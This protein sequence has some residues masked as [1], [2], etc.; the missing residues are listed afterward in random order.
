M[1]NVL[2]GVLLA[3]PWLACL[4]LAGAGAGS[5]PRGR[6][7]VLFT[8][9]LI[10]VG[11][12]FLLI[13]HEEPTLAFG[14][15]LTHVTPAATLSEVAWSA[16][17]FSLVM[18]AATMLLLA[19]ATVLLPDD[20]PAVW[21]VTLLVLGGVL[22]IW[23]LQHVWWI[24]GATI[25]V[26]FLALLLPTAGD[27]PHTA[28]PARSLW[29]T[30]TVGDLALIVA[31]IAG[32]GGIG[33]GTV[34]RFDDAETV[35]E[36]AAM[37][38]A[39]AMFVGFWW[40]IGILGRAGQFPLCVMFDRVRTYRPLAWVTVVGVSVFAIGWRWCDLGHAWWAATPSVF[41]LIISGALASALLCAWFAACTT[42]FRVRVAYLTAAQISLGLG[43][44]CTGEADERVWASAVV[45]GTIGL[46]VWCWC[47][48]TSPADSTERPD[49]TAAAPAWARVMTGGEVSTVAW[50]WSLSSPSVTSSVLPT[51]APSART[52]APV[53][54]LLWCGL[55]IAAGS[56][57]W[58][59]EPLQMIAD[60]TSSA[61]EAGSA[62]ENIA[63]QRPNGS[64][65]ISALAVGLISSSVCAG[66]RSLLR[67]SG[68]SVHSLPVWVASLTLASLPA[69]VL[70]LLSH[71]TGL[72]TT[73]SSHT[74]PALACLA[75]AA[76]VTGWVWAG[77][78]IEQ[79]RKAAEP[80]NLIRQLGAQRLLIP[81]LLQFGANFP[82]RG[83]AQMFRFLDWSVLE[84]ACWGR[85]RNFPE[86][87]RGFTQE[88]R[89][90][91]NGSYTLVLWVSGTA[92]VTTVV[93]LA[94]IAR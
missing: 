2:L 71:P 86:T 63:P 79:Q 13:R 84:I 29:L 54:A 20:A 73:L 70:V 7:T 88:L 23:W 90:A 57:W 19:A 46:A 28:G 94:H 21:M 16:N 72:W 93:W 59:D 78:P 42:D 35:R 10:G 17:R 65:P 12:L 34:G 50:Q 6:Q 68:A 60:S 22:Q 47:V 55:A 85:L 38:P 25:L 26:S 52:M 77:W 62:L 4:T 89:D 8:T 91:G 37:R 3:L 14:P 27:S 64:I 18:V 58:S 30:V 11:C 53:M 31:I 39:T 9:V 32:I 49:D 92:L 69:W 87:A 67:A 43:P 44:L 56:W 33:H 61:D 45:M 5:S 40:W 83:L 15:A 48:V 76:L 75:L 74:S 82:L 24:A 36:F 80:F 66:L 51:I 41:N 1:A 81:G